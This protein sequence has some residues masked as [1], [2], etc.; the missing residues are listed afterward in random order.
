MLVPDKHFCHGQACLHVDV[1][2]C[3]MQYTHAVYM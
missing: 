1:A 3:S 2:S